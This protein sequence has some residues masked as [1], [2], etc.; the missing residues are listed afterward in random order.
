MCESAPEPTETDA[1]R[2]EA[3]V[4]A[5]DV[6]KVL[7]ELTLDEKA[8]LV[9]GRDHWHT[10]A[11]ERL[12]V[13]T[14]K[15]TDGP[16]GARG[17]VLFDSGTPTL[18]VPCGSA[19]GAMWDPALV[20]RIGAALGQQART[21]GAHVL[22][23]P[24]VNLHRHPLAGRNFECYSEDPFLTA[25][26]AVAFVRGVQGQGVAT[27]TKHFAGNES[28]YKRMTINSVV[29]ER[30]LRELYL[31]PFEQVVAR[32]DAWGIMA[33]Y[34]RLNG[35]YCT[36]SHW[37]L[38]ELLKEEWGFD[39]FVVS[40]WLATHSTVDAA[41]SGLDLEMPGPPAWFGPRLADAV[42][43][44][45]VDE[46]TLDDMIR[47]LLLLAERTDAFD[48]PPGEERGEELPEHRDLARTA[49]A[50]AMVLLKNDGNVLPLD[51]DSLSSLAVLGPNASR[52]VV[53]GGGSATVNPHRRVSP[54]HALSERLG[55]GVDIRHEVGGYAH[56][57]LPALT[58]PVLTTPD[59][60]PGMRVEYFGT[61]DLSGDVVR[62]DVVPQ[63][64]L[65][66]IGEAPDGVDVQ[67]FSMRATGMLRVEQD[68]PF[69]IGLV[70]LGRARVLLDG[71]ELLDGWTQ[72]LP[73]GEALMGFASQEI[74]ATAELRTG[75]PV[76]LVV[77][78]TND[79]TPGF[80]AC[81]VGGRPAEPD[82]ALERAAAVAAGADA[83]VVFVGTD[84]E[85]E[86]EGNDRTSY[87]LPGRQAQLVERVASVNP[88][89]VVVLNAGAPVDTS[90]AES[91][92][93][94]LV[95][96]FGGQEMADAIVDVL[97]GDA[98]PGGRL[99]TTY[100]RQLED[101]PCFFDYPGDGAEVRY[102]E[103]VFMGYRGYDAR[104]VEPAWPFGH[105]LSYTEFEYGDIEVSASEVEI[106]DDLHITARV[107]V[108]NTGARPGR[109]VV[110]LYVA[111]RSPR[112]VRPPQEL[113][114]FAKLSLEPGE[115]QQ[116]TLTLGFRSFAAW[117]PDRHG[118]VADAGD[119]EIRSGRSSRDIRARRV[120][121]L[122]GSESQRQS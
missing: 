27:T 108:T 116:V 87:D 41:R 64:R 31:V 39:G 37:L 57:T 20:E 96:W 40:D 32:A 11:I 19:L 86:T 91:V 43:A 119:Y 89:T 107:T 53:M 59:G 118:W 122:R 67:R 77:E 10:V 17:D 16:N 90:W 54:L 121:T 83:A 85:W 42:R 78:F 1:S 88:R 102:G 14:I 47:R 49:A 7:A 60:E 66:W 35:P 5:I 63:S 23:A 97:T 74:T 12:D 44:G 93:A 104:A 71:T 52:A 98:D 21:K 105:G 34:N 99:P 76:E 120:V 62:V 72:R 80:G 46:A 18:C 84:E 106:T 50:G 48:L 73:R 111:P 30:A 22:L 24:T 45:D 33:A 100:P 15:V 94:V 65:R 115:R 75:A 117:D 82:D 26:A 4:R 8:A 112:L 70:V 114:A 69:E 79:R 58:P 61:N 101:V 56:K 95:S 109:E 2:M 51:V 113:K 28:E 68:G 25:E 9:A 103:G 3:T 13:G 92:P 81:F 29:P 55:D 38:T 110:Q 36:D 6:D